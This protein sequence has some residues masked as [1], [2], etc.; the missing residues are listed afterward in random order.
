MAISPA[1]HPAMYKDSQVHSPLAVSFVMEKLRSQ[2]VKGPA[3]GHLDLSTRGPGV[4]PPC[5]LGDSVLS[6]GW[7]LRQDGLKA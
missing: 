4:P 3:R 7:T 1:K 2:K 5:L 6:V